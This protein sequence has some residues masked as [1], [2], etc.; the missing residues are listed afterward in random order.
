VPAAPVR[1][2]TEVLA[3][4]HLH[5]RGYLVEVDH[6]EMGTVTLP[7]SP[8]RYEGSPMPSLVP[9]PA[10]GQHTAEVLDEWLGL[11]PSEVADLRS[12]GAV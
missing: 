4:R 3:D 10:L 7:R 12:A 2:L 9:S 6:P 1:D 8:I 5:E 11:G